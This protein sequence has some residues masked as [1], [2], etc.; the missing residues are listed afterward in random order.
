MG[1]TK[2]K[3]VQTPF[4]EQKTQEN[5]YGTVSFADSPEAQSLLSAPL[6]F[7]QS[8]YSGDAY[9]DIPTQ[10]NL[11]PGVGR[12]TDLAEQANQ[13]RWDSSFMGG[14][15]REYRQLLRDSETRQIR[16]QGA[17]EAQQAEY[18]RQGLQAEAA[19]QRAQMR[20]ASERTKAGFAGQATNAD[21]ERRRLL[22][23]Q[24]VQ[25]S[26]TSSSSG[27]NTQIMPGQQ[28]IL[29]QLAQG[30]GSVIGGMAAGGML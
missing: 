10:F 26:G 2:A 5:T 12:R 27:Y 16:S 23:P 3:P 28:G 24:I 11:D 1:G 8:A 19:T 17:A 21:L 29:G 25:K 18:G 15:P 30:A 9:K 14:I 7:G 13:Q 4:Q 22:L 6:D 20:D